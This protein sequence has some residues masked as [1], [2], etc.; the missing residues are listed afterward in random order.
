MQMKPRNKKSRGKNRRVR[1]EMSVELD[2]LISNESKPEEQLEK[3]GKVYAA[4]FGDKD[5]KIESIKFVD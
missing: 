1:I 4:C 2:A 5:I 3:V